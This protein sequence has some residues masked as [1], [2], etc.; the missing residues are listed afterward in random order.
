ML[1]AGYEH[2]RPRHPL[3]DCSH[4]PDNTAARQNGPSRDKR[5]GI[6]PN[7]LYHALRVR[8]NG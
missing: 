2:A 5:W 3:N 4:A 7:H 6:G 1:G 8:P